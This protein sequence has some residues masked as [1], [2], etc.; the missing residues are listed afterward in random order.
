MCDGVPFTDDQDHS[1]DIGG[2]VRQIRTDKSGSMRISVCTGLVAGKSWASISRPGR[3]SKGAPNSTQTFPKEN[4]HSVKSYGSAGKAVKDIDYGP[5]DRPSIFRL[6]RFMI[7]IG[8]KNHQGSPE[9]FRPVIRPHGR[10]FRSKTYAHANKNA[11]SSR[12]TV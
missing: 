5:R 12:Q 3:P 8:V 6:S 9:T 1:I 11:G 7:G 2:S 4:G 10:R